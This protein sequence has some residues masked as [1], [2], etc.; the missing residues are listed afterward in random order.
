VFVHTHTTVRKKQ[1]A[2]LIIAKLD[3]LDRNLAFIANIMESKVE[4]L[5]VAIRMQSP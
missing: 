3:R 5:A 4:F 2:T 1:K